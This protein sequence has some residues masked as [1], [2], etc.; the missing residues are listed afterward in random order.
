MI[1]VSVQQST[2]ICA[3]LVAALTS[4]VEDVVDRSTCISDKPTQ[5]KISLSAI[6]LAAEV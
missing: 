3:I 6:E 2:G 1:V 5:Q 4:E